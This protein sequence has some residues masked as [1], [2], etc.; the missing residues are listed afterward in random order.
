MGTLSCT[1]T[2]DLCISRGNLLRTNKNLGDVIVKSIKIEN[3]NGDII[4]LKTEIGDW[5]RDVVNAELDIA[6]LEDDFNSN[7]RKTSQTL[8]EIQYAITLLQTNSG[9]PKGIAGVG[10]YRGF[11]AEHKKYLIDTQSVKNI[12][13]GCQSFALLAGSI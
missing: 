10:K 4:D 13:V 8:S 9:S 5:A 11:S 2:L 3:E 12:H 1:Q 7:R 6:D